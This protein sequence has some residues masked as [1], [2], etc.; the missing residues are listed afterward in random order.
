ME[1]IVKQNSGGVF[2]CSCMEICR[3][4]AIKENRL[5]YS[6]KSCLLSVNHGDRCLAY[7]EDNTTWLITEDQSQVRQ[8]QNI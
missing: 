3:A 2:E 5:N 4:K 7:P 8:I 6:P 1:G